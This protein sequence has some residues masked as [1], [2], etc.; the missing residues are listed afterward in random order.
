[1]KSGLGNVVARRIIIILALLLP[2]FMGGVEGLAWLDRREIAFRLANDDAGR[3]VE[4]VDAS[5]RSAG[6][7][8]GPVA[9]YYRDAATVIADETIQARKRRGCDWA[10]ETR[11]VQAFDGNGA[12]VWRPSAHGQP[13]YVGSSIPNLRQDR[14]ESWNRQVALGAAVTLPVRYA[15]TLCLP[16]GT[17]VG[18]LVPFEGGAIAVL[19]LIAFDWTAYLKLLAFAYG[20]LLAVWLLAELLAWQFNVALNRRIGRITAILKTVEQNGFTDR[21]PLDGGPEFAVLGE[22]INSMIARTG[23]AHRYFADLNGFVAHNLRSPLTV[24]RTLVDGLTSRVGVDD[25]A[26]LGEIDLQLVE[27]DRRCCELLDRARLETAS[28]LQSGSVDLAVTIER[29][30]EDIFLYLAMEKEMSIDLD[31]VPAPIRMAGATQELIIDNLL[32][33]ALKFG[34]EGTD[35]Q[36]T[37]TIERN[38]AHLGVSNQGASVPPYLFE[39][40]FDRG[41]TTGGHGLGLYAVRTAAQLHGGNAVALPLNGG[42]QVVVTL[43]VEAYST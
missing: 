20:A 33:N 13:V 40:I 29:Q 10:R 4:A 27:L 7:S 15:D 39:A 8:K 35:V 17:A 25:S 28:T 21:V 9:V 32:Q 24:A 23:L 19:R 2:F 34:L 1:M 30:V 43:P 14:L 5:L 42:F 26:L 36:V 38:V 3:M 12:P 18:V 41:Y 22:E 37:L 16:D 11:L 6:P 31:L